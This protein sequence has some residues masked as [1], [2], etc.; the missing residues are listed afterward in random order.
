MLL[1]YLDITPLFLLT[2]V[3]ANPYAF[4]FDRDALPD[5]FEQA[6]AGNP[7]VAYYQVAAVKKHACAKGENDLY[8]SGGNNQRQAN[9]ENMFNSS[10]YEKAERL[11]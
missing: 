6:D 9:G 1:R 3:S 5:D 7:N 8:C 4:D 2:L 11:R 10:Y